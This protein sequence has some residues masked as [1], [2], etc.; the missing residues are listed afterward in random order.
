M[1]RF[2]PFF[3]VCYVLHAEMGGLGSVRLKE[4]IAVPPAL[5]AECT[6]IFVL[7]LAVL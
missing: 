7:E 4:N 6:G 3:F 5:S 2:D 1:P